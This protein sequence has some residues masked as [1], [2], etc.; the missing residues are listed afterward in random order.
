[1]VQQALV[2]IGKTGGR[3][4][5]GGGDGG[6]GGGREGGDS[7]S[8]SN[9]HKNGSRS[10]LGWGLLGLEALSLTE[11][12]EVVVLDQKVGSVRVSR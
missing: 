3:G 9:N 6:E 5:G 10:R 7:G 11:Y 2:A 1:M 8:S 12:G 4:D